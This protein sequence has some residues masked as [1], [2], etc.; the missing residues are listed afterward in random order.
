MR[1]QEGRWILAYNRYLGFCFV[2]EAELWG[3]LDRLTLILEWSYDFL[4]IQTD[5]VEAVQAIQEHAQDNG[6]TNGIAKLIQ[7]RREGLQVFEASPLGS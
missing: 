1:D 5:S 6:E 2:M 7:E 4:I 3:I